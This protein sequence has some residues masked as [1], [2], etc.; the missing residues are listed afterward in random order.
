MKKILLSRNWNEKL[1]CDAFLV[2][3][4]SSSG[5]TTGDK[6]ELDVQ[7]TKCIVTYLY[8]IVSS[9]Y[10]INLKDIPESIFYADCGLSKHEASKNYLNFYKQ[11]KGWNVLVLERVKNNN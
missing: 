2:I 1:C 9:E 5:Y 8:Y 3:R 11:D 10:Y 6:I 7:L 4:P